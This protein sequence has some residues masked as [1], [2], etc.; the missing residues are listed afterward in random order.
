MRAFRTPRF[1]RKPGQR[2]NRQRFKI[3]LQEAI[4]T[5]MSRRA[6]R[7]EALVSF[8]HSLRVSFPSKSTTSLSRTFLCLRLREI[9]FFFK[10]C[11]KDSVL[12]R[13]QH[14]DRSGVWLPGQQSRTDQVSRHAGCRYFLGR[15]AGALQF[16]HVIA[17]HM[18]FEYPKSNTYERA[19]AIEG[20]WTIQ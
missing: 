5:L 20:V 3:P 16:L 13:Q 18:L 8:I 1:T 17:R 9:F 7:E 19:G 11:Q 4:C 10:S 6:V 15:F 2:I 12:G 14:Q